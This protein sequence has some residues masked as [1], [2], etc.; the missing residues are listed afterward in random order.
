MS[1]RLRFGG[2]HTAPRPPR[3]YEQRVDLGYR[4][5]ILISVVYL[6]VVALPPIGLVWA[7]AI[8]TVGVLSVLL[9]GRI[10]QLGRPLPEQEG[11]HRG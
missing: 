11:R 9:L 3:T 2:A 4:V 10:L 7:A 5:A 6:A 1:A 8:L